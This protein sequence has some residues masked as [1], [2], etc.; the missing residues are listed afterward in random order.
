MEK[1]KSIKTALSEKEFDKLKLM[2]KIINSNS[3]DVTIIK[4]PSKTEMRKIILANIEKNL[5]IARKLSIVLAER[6]IQ[7]RKELLKDRGK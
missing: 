5:D 4:G 6:Y 1:G 2:V 3:S 7:L